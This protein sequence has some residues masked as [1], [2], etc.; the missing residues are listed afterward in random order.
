MYLVDFL[1]IVTYALSEVNIFYECELVS[2][3]S[4]RKL[5][6]LSFK[7]FL[8]TEE[9]DFFSFPVCGNTILNIL[10]LFVQNSSAF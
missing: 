4:N 1:Q 2:L 8:C 5:K 10:C 9:H 6:Y 3:Y 7:V